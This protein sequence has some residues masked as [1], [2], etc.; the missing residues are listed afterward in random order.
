[1]LSSRWLAVSKQVKDSSWQRNGDVCDVL[2][3]GIIIGSSN[4]NDNN[5]NSS[6]NY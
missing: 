5:S 2:A 1:M 4:S 3:A 6:S